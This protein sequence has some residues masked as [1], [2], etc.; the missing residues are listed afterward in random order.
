VLELCEALLEVPAVASVLSHV[1]AMRPKSDDELD[2]RVAHTLG[3]L[4]LKEPRSVLLL[5]DADCG[6]FLVPRVR[7]IEEAF[8]AFLPGS[9]AG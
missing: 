8:R 5:G 9:A 6:S 1:R 7:G 4:W 3:E 2:A